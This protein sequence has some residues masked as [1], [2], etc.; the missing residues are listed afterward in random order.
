MMFHRFWQIL[1]AFSPI[2]ILVVPGGQVFGPL[3]MSVVGWFVLSWVL[4]DAQTWQEPIRHSWRL[5]LTGFGL[6]VLSNGL[7]GWWHD[8]HLGF[9]EMF[10]PFLL[11]PGMGWLIIKHRL[12]SNGW[13]VSVAIAAFLGLILAIYQVFVL[14]VGRAFGEVGN[15]ITFGNTAA[16]LAAVSLIAAATYPLKKHQTWMKW[17][18]YAGG[19]SGLLASL[20]SGS[21]GGWLSLLTILLTVAYLI[22][23]RWST[24]KKRLFASICV[25]VLFL[26]AFMMPS[27]VV[28]DRLV[29]GWNGGIHWIKTGEVTEGSVSI[30]FEMWTLS[31]EIFTEKIWAGHGSNG[32]RERWQSLISEGKYDPQLKEIFTSDNELLG[33]LVSG[34]AI[35]TAGLLLVYVG[36]WAGFWR[37][38]KHADSQVRSYA[39]M[40]LILI[41][42]YLEFGLSVAV[43]GTGIFRTVLVTFSVVLLSLITVRLRELKTN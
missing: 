26:V 31:W 39:L 30:R 17:V 34:G 32:V 11:L 9:Y 5:M 37:W 24:V 35:G 18:F 43:L 19:L 42:L 16:V 33:S 13:L 15:P 40:G 28:K 7:L 20:L 23:E 38:R 3:I 2:A 41:P 29:S 4:N 6:F 27:H 10:L 1:F 21:K 8:N 14:N 25:G 36:I 22:A 12:H